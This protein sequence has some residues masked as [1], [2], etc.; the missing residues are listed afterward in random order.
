[1]KP[2]NE[3]QVSKDAF[4][5][6]LAKLLKNRPLRAKKVKTRGNKSKGTVLFKKG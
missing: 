2:T 6:A 5:S 4:E 1:M 3:I